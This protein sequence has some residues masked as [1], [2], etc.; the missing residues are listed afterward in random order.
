[1]VKSRHDGGVLD[2]S[3]AGKSIIDSLYIFGFQKCNQSPS[4]SGASW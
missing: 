2:S 3:I 1:M 4:N